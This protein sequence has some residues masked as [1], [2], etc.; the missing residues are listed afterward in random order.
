MMLIGL[1]FLAGRRNPLKGL[2]MSHVN[3]SNSERNVVY[4]EGDGT[5]GG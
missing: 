5:S 2:S 4:E 1:D 3:Y